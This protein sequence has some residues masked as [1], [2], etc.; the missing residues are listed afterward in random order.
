MSPIMSRKASVVVSAVASSSLLVV[1]LFGAA[2]AGATPAIPVH[3]HSGRGIIT[4]EGASG[5]RS[6][7][8]DGSAAAVSG[9]R[10]L[11]AN[12]GTTHLTLMDLI[13]GAIAWFL[14]APFSLVASQST[15]CI[16]TP[17][18]RSCCVGRY[19]QDPV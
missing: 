11:D 2:P 12:D 8:Q 4:S 3:D 18:A 7:Y 1:L 14:G 13:R 10:L 9:R 19:R 15:P 16:T 6:A 17:Q 5:A